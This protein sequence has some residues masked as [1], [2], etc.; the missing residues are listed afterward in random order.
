MNNAAFSQTRLS[1]GTES[2]APVA[3]LLSNNLGNRLQAAGSILNVTSQLPQVRNTSY[4][5]LINETLHGIPQDADIEKRQID[6][7]ML[8]SRKDFQIIV[9]IMPNGD[10]Y[11]DEPFARQ[12]MSTLTNLA[13]RDY[14]KGVLETNDTFLSNVN[15]SASS[16][17]RQALI[18]VPV[19][20]LE[21]NS[22]LAGL[23][24][25]GLDIDVLN[26]DLRSLNLTTGKRV[27]YVDH[28]GSK[29]AD[30]DVSN[31]NPEESFG[32]LTSFNTIAG[33]AG[34]LT[35]RIGNENMT[36]TYEPV[37]AFH[38]TWAVL[39]IERKG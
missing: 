37:E 24:V 39:L 32:N 36:V 19:Y 38:N 10:I 12:E 25:G 8:S 2:D 34:S 31:T 33:E 20:S 28:N 22:T 27:V 16:G 5:D 18:A 9:F 13:S 26:E 11:L 1:G 30:S 17:Q 14:F 3:K 15:T 35:E 21:D 29:I 6:Q 23:W 7:N 4:A